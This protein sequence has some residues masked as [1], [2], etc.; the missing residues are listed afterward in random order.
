MT[1]TLLLVWAAVSNPTPTARAGRTDPGPVPPNAAV[2]ETTGGNR[3][4]TLG[5]AYERR[6]RPHLSGG[7][8]F[9]YVFP[10]VGSWHLQGFGE[11]VQVS[12][13]PWEVGRGFYGRGSFG[14][15]HQVFALDA[16]LRGIAIAPGAGGGWRWRLRH[17]INVGVSAALHWVVPI[18]RD[19]RICTRASHCPAIRRGVDAGAGV[20]VGYAF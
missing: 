18:A 15:R 8:A 9:R 2:L 20:D 19:D 16:S 1:L 7:I 14:V 6:F 5:I 13:W 12:A 17:G 4:F 3:G 11:A 10:P